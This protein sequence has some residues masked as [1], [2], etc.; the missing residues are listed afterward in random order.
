M[1]SEGIERALRIAQEAHQGQT[2]KSAHVP[3]VVH[4]VHVALLLARSGANDETIQ[5]GILHDVVEDCEGWTLEKVED[6]FGQH[7]AA[8]V[9]ELTE[10]KRLPWPERKQAQ[11]DSVAEMSKEAATV[12][13]TDQLHNL[14]SLLSDLRESSNT[15][16][17]WSHFTASPEETM[18]MSRVMVE[19]LVRRVD[20][21]LGEALIRV[22]EDLE[23][24]CSR[25]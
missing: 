9:G 23:Q 22:L 16:E 15:A 2:R 14:S 8:I 11:V 18:A 6:H 1:F 25:R 19:T 3:Y 12:K 20:R 7:V 24:E 10:D 4:P 13:A 21:K 17:V 5:A